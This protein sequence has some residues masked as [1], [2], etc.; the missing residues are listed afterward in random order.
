VDWVQV[1]ADA[2]VSFRVDEREREGPKH[3]VFHNFDTSD[4]S[5]TWSS[6]QQL[7]EDGDVTHSIQVRGAPLAS[8]RSASGP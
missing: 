2:S 3:V 1:G 4:P 7:N 8:P 6:I 5:T